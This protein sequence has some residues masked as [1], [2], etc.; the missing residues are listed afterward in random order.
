MTCLQGVE[1]M[2]CICG[3]GVAVAHLAYENKV[4]CCGTDGGKQRVAVGILGLG[5]TEEGIH[6]YHA[7]VL[8]ADSI[9]HNCD[10]GS[11]A[12]ADVDHYDGGIGSN[13]IIITE[14]CE[15]HVSK[16][17]VTKCLRE[18]TQEAEVLGNDVQQGNRRT[19]SGNDP[20]RIE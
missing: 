7:R 4:R 1:W 3:I 14:L 17:E 15:H 16:I 13:I 12:V 2:V 19:G 20:D 18:R 5:L 11:V 9:D 10:L 6:A 8:S